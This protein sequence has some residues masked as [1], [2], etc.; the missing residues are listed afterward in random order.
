[1]D[2][3]AGLVLNQLSW[4]SFADGILHATT[5]GN[6]PWIAF[7]LDPWDLPRA[8]RYK[9]AAVRIRRSPGGVATFLWKQQTGGW[10]G[11][12]F[13][14]PDDQWVTKVVD[15]GQATGWENEIT[16]FRLDPASSENVALS[17][18]WVLLSEGDVADESFTLAWNLE[19]SALVTFEK[20]IVDSAD[21]SPIP[22]GTDLS[23]PGG[24]GTLDWSTAGLSS[25]PYEL[26][27]HV[28]WG[29]DEE[30]ASC[31]NFLRVNRLPLF[32]MTAPASTEQVLEGVDLATLAG[33][34]WDMSDPGDI[35][36]YTGFTDVVFADGSFSGVTSSTDPVIAFPSGMFDSQ[37]YSL[38]AWSMR[39]SEETSWNVYWQDTSNAW[40]YT[41]L[42]GSAMAGTWAT[43]SVD[44]SQCSEWN[45][46]VKN[47]RIDPTTGPGILVEIDWV[48]MVTPETA[49]L[50]VGW[51]LWDG[52]ADPMLSVACVDQTGNETPVLEDASAQ[53]GQSTST[54]DLSVLPPGLYTIVG[55]LDDHAHQPVEDTAPGALE[56]LPRENTPPSVTVLTPSASDPRLPDKNEFSRD[57]LEDSWDFAQITDG[58]LYQNMTDVS[59]ED[60][61]LVATSANTDPYFWL[62][63]HGWDSAQNV[64]KNGQVY[65]IDPG[66]FKLASWRM[67]LD[68]SSYMYIYYYRGATNSD[69]TTFA[70][71]EHIAVYEGWHTYAVRLDT[72]DQSVSEGLQGWGTCDVINGLRIDPTVVPG[73]TIMIDWFRLSEVGDSSTEADIAWLVEDDLGAAQVEVY[74]D[75]QP[76]GFNGE[77]ILGPMPATGT[78]QSVPYCTAHLPHP[79]G[80]VY[81][82]A[83]DGVNEPVRVYAPGPIRINDVPLVRVRDPDELGPVEFAVEVQDN[84]WDMD[85]WD[86]VEQL[87]DVQNPEIVGGELRGTTTSEDAQVHLELQSPLNTR[88]FASARVRQWTDVWTVMRLLWR[89]NAVS[90]WQVTDDFVMDPGWNEYIVS[91]MEDLVLEPD[92]G[93]GWEDEI[94]A[95]FRLDPAEHAGR[96]FR[97]DYVQLFTHDM[98]NDNFTLK[99]ELHDLD[100]DESP[101]DLTWYWKTSPESPDSNLIA[102]V[103]ACSP[104]LD[105][106]VWDMSSLQSAE[107][108]VY[109]IA[110]DGLN[111]TKH[112]AR[113]VLVLNRSPVFSFVEPDGQDD[114]ID[115]G[116]DFAS[117]VLDDPWDM[118]TDSDIDYVAGFD[119]TSVEWDGE[120]FHGVT[121]FDPSWS[122]LPPAQS[123]IDANHYRT[124]SLRLY[125]DDPAGASL[126]MMVYWK[127]TL[128]GE[129]LHT[130]FLTASQGWNTYVIDLG[131][132]APATWTGLVR[133][134]RIDPVT[135]ADVTV[136]LDWVR[137]TNPG[138][139]T[140]TI[141]WDDDD[142]DDD[143]SIQLTA[144]RG[145]WE[146]DEITIAADLSE[147][148]ETN[149]Y[150]WDVSPFP[151]SLYY[152]KVCIDDGINAPVPVLCP[153][154][155]FVG[156]Q[157][158][159]PVEIESQMIAP[160]T[161]L[162]TWSAP[163]EPVD[164]YRVYKASEPL[165]DLC[166]LFLLAEIEEEFYAAYLD[167]AAQNPELNY[168]FRVT[169]V[170]PEGFES[171]GSQAVGVTDF[172]LNIP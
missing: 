154:P 61:V 37:S 50:P 165:F 121:T 70:A 164:T 12:A 36:Y 49:A 155:V 144:Y 33:N 73:S 163:S 98:A 21:W 137:L 75:L 108:Y 20:S 133:S 9:S 91:D 24:P 57:I 126:Q 59:I 6:D 170:S 28:R 67:Y 13:T 78:V 64:G 43:Y 143:A 84:S 118:N 35:D 136:E 142:P 100:T 167:S 82:S 14:C 23:L 157:G 159:D 93:I 145:S 26:R 134:F 92:C 101:T 68:T 162:L 27:A 148:D 45:G 107:Y 125:L 124:L 158:V 3:G 95:F 56:I 80:Y 105:S 29:Q 22:E 127:H 139:S 65:P 166:P 31:E 53:N 111:S 15:L 66:R 5:A 51:T 18:D 130:G 113:G 120:V 156:F 123:P 79:G 140:Y 62:L 169:W 39:V 76:W 171:P 48:R 117:S 88:R 122:W 11:E 131:A 112:G 44:L 30:F 8:D 87:V 119:P 128:A 114:F 172:L 106:L 69:T 42:Q 25:N 46:V 41:D 34:P 99:W 40:H 4:V 47:L 97:L 132:E 152:L 94:V 74:L 17:V 32:I 146:G 54:V 110:D 96:M 55:A 19:H 58:Y 153:N 151:E 1:M 52:E 116:D 16:A 7:A 86:D 85:S 135:Q 10:N 77:K 168:Y 109:C 160:D 72:L 81:V 103:P 147:D 102:T 149:Q 141:V 63:H 138:S 161:L 150:T 38:I 2:S 115:I 60:S 83:D 90:T 71:T 104:G 129:W 89:H